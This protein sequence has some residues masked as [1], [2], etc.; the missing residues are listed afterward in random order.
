VTRFG[1]ERKLSLGDGVVALAGA[2]SAEI[3]VKETDLIPGGYLYRGV[4]SPAWLDA[5]G[6][7]KLDISAAV[8]LSPLAGFDHRTVIRR[9]GRFEV[10]TAR[11]NAKGDRD[12]P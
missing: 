7:H 3:D 1:T 11:D 12:S 5:A 4:Q 6:R 8:D 2:A 9:L 10:R